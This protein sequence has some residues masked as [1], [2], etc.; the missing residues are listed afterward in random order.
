MRRVSSLLGHI[1]RDVGNA[2]LLIAAF[3]VMFLAT[4][5]AFRVTPSWPL[6]VA[7]PP[8]E[9]TDPALQM[10][11]APRSGTFAIRATD[12]A[13]KQTTETARDLPT[14]AS[15]GLVMVSILSGAWNYRLFIR[16]RSARLMTVKKPA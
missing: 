13:A 8:T 3:L 6:A 16:H 7:E 4:Q 1:Q 9:R 15:L 2:P 5:S 12:Q 11:Q 10:S 14:L